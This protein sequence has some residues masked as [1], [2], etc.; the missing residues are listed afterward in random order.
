M[1]WV[2]VG[3]RL[4]GKFDQGKEIAFLQ[5]FNPAPEEGSLK[6]TLDTEP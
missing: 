2:K 6:L 1:K 3:F 4:E 5:N